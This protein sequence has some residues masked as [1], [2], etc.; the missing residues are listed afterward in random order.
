MWMVLSDGHT[1]LLADHIDDFIVS[2]ERP[3][4]HSRQIQLSPHGR[5]FR[6][7]FR[8]P[9]SHLPWLWNHL[10]P[11][12]YPWRTPLCSFRNTLSVSGKTILFQLS[13]PL[14]PHSCLS[15]KD[16]EEPPERV[17]GSI[18]GYRGIVGSSGYLVHIWCAPTWLS[19]TLSSANTFRV[20]AWHIWMLR[21]YPGRKCPVE[22][23]FWIVSL[24]I[25]DTPLIDTFWEL[26]D[27]YW[28]AVVNDWLY[29]SWE[30][31]WLW[32]GN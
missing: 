23:H 32:W 8:G 24:E 10:S 16:C 30:T 15:K 13:F 18:C 12:K 3:P 26:V 6:W 31:G 7:Y 2:C 19:R 11:A 25:F 1:I 17:S 20:L 22:G 9:H 5:A 28:S 29:K 4:T 14:P 27:S 21:R